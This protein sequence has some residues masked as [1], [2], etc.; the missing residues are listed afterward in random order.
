M[1]KM[2]KLIPAFA[3]LLVSAIMMS[4][5][6]FA[7]FTMNE[8]VTA[9]GMQVQAKAAGN[10]LIGMDKMTA[11]D[12][13][14]SVNLDNTKQTLTPITYKEGWKVPGSAVEIDPTFGTYVDD[15]NALVAESV[16]YTLNADDHF[17]DYVIYLATAGSEMTNQNLWVRIEGLSGQNQK[18]APAYSI[19]FYAD[20]DDDGVIDEADELLDTVN[21]EEFLTING[22]AAAVEVTV[23]TGLTIPSTYGATSDSK[24]GLRIF[25][26][27]YVDGDLNAEQ[28]YSKVPTYVTYEA[29]DMF[30]KAS[31]SDLF[32]YEANDKSQTVDI[33]AWDSNTDISNY[34]SWDGTTMENG[35]LTDTKYVNNAWVPNGSTTFSVIMG[36]DE[37][38]QQQ[39]TNP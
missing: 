6:S 8:E 5:A 31:M 15:G 34:V 19:A 22:H 33:S 14:I 13:A 7:W 30:D 12:Q 20:K 2:R 16:S 10:L 3:M 11:Q 23:G 4:T 27:V 24:V 26:R 29:G 38:A 28:T 39:P 37:P 32:F 35:D 21:Y 18:I 9:T 1:K 25:M 36:V 17:A